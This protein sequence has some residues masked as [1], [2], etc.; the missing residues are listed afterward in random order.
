MKSYLEKSG[1]GNGPAD[2]GSI[3][4]ELESFNDQL[5]VEL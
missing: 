1:G 5:K 3:K 2:L 4:A